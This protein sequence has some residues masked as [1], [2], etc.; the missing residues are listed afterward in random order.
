MSRVFLVFVSVLFLSAC[1]PQEEQDSGEIKIVVGEIGGR[2]YFVPEAYFKFKNIPFA[3]ES[4]YLQTMYPDFLPLTKRS[5]KYWEE[6]DWWRN[7]SVLAQYHPN[8]TLTTEDFVLN[9]VEFLK[10][11]EFVGEEYGLLHKKQPK[12]YIQDH[13][14]V[15]LEAHNGKIRSIVICSEKLIESDAPQCSQNYYLF[16]KLRLRITY[17]KK[18]LKNWREID[19]SIRKLFKSF[20]TS[21]A[22][23]AF[24]QQQTLLAPSLEQE[25]KHAEH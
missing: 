12:E 16:P 5:L 17:D 15:W 2:E 23:Q 10:A 6:G 20:E 4:I 24:L 9:Q 3:E 25:S 8:S 1:L 22:A 19:V 7:V 13:K 14:D 11:F 21:E 18:L